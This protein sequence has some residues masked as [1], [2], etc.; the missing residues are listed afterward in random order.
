MAA[1]VYVIWENG[2]GAVLKWDYDDALLTVTDLHITVPSGANSC[3][4]RISTGGHIHD[5]TFA[6]GADTNVL[7]AQSPTVAAGPVFT[8]IDYVGVG[9]S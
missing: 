5:Q 7:L 9:G 8:G 4:L 1:A 6:A 3:L 2:E